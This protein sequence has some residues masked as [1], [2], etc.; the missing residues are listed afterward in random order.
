MARKPGGIPPAGVRFSDDDDANTL[1][2]SEW[3][4]RHWPKEAILIEGINRPHEVQDNTSLP[5]GRS[6]VPA[7]AP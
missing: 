3:Q 6:V 5:M 2:R 1:A 7:V 4:L